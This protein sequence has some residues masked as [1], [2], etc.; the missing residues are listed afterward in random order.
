MI[1]FVF[2]DRQLDQGRVGGTR[3]YPIRGL[4]RDQRRVVPPEWGTQ[5]EAQRRAKGSHDENEHKWLIVQA[6]LR[7][8]STVT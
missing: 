4:E 2:P 1:V 5:R 7:V 8:L 6:V 3:T